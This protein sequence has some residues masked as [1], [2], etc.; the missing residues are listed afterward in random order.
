MGYCR[1]KLLAV[2]VNSGNGRGHVK[3]VGQRDKTTVLEPRISTVLGL[4]IPQLGVR[5][6]C[7]QSESR[8]QPGCRQVWFLPEPARAPR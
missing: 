4:E 1:L 7:G 8:N 5:S 2:M 3:R 6:V